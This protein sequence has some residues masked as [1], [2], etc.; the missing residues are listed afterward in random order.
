MLGCVV[1]IEP[2]TTGFT[3]R[4][5]TTAPHAPLKRIGLRGEVRTPD[6]MLPK[7]V[8]YQLRYAEKRKW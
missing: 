1:G 8:R 7:H 6:P 5:A 4:S 3:A 2:T